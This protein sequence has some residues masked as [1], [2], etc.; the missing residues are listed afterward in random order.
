MKKRWNVRFAA[1]SDKG[2]VRENNEDNLYIVGKSIPS[3]SMDH[4][5]LDGEITGSS[6]AC[7]VCDGMGG[8]N[9]GEVAS[10]EAVKR[11]GQM[12][13]NNGFLELPLQK[14]IDG[15]QEYLGVANTAIFNMASETTQSRGMGTTFA[16]VLASDG[17]AVAIHAG[18][19]RV[20]LCRKNVLHQL[21]RDHSESERMIRLGV[22]SPEQARVHKSRYVVN[23][24]LGMPPEAGMLEG[25]VS[26]FLDLQQ[27]DI[28]VLCSDGLTD[29][30]EQAQMEQVLFS[31]A[32]LHEKADRL[33]GAALANGGKDNVTVLLIETEKA[34]LTPVVLS[35]AEKQSRVDKG[36]KLSM[37]T[38]R[39]V[40]ALLIL[41]AIAAGI[42]LRPLVEKQAA[43][44]WPGMFTTPTPTLSPTPTPMVTPSTTF[45]PTPT[46]TA[47]PT[48]TPTLRPTQTATHTPMLTPTPTPRFTLTQTPTPTVAQAPTFKPD[49]TFATTPA[50]TLMPNASPTFSIAKLNSRYSVHNMIAF[51]LFGQGYRAA[52]G[53]EA[54]RWQI[55]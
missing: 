33:I 17:K 12:V 30:V 20:Y 25:D 54:L 28:F 2:A 22:L 21:T 7:A 51:E 24:H 38:K 50:V 15:V 41:F 19:S 36:G 44:L 3:D 39:L 23:R 9:N 26:D 8:Q 13:D 32:P 53:K 55:L 40:I 47:T 35:E 45:T 34:N 52:C 46:P 16:C 11:F 37:R 48:L 43:V 49:P 5:S 31:S 14:K 4:V 18:D 6:F 10:F 42:L 29:M 1:R 27:G